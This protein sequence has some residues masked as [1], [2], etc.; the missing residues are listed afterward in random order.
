[1]AA[2]AATS[3]ATP[4]SQAWAGRARLDQARRQAEQAEAKA[5]ALRVQANQAEQEAQ[6]D[7]QKVRAIGAQ[8]AQAD[9]TYSSQLRQQSAARGSRQ[10]QGLL[11]ANLG[12]MVDASA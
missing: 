4:S 7:Q 8:V 10:V 6:K 9:S 3:Y 5:S 11:R 2:I 12:R 1:M